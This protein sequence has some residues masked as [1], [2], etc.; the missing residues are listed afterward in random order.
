M[1][2][3]PVLVIDSGAALRGVL[4]LPVRREPTCGF[5]V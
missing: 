4:Q 1:T 5:G 2:P 3:A